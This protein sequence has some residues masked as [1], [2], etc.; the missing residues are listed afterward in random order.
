MYPQLDHEMPLID[1]EPSTKAK[2]KAKEEGKSRRN[3]PCKN[4]N[5]MKL[6]KKEVRNECTEKVIKFL[7]EPNTG[8]PTPT[9]IKSPTNTANSANTNTIQSLRE[10]GG[11]I[12]NV[13]QRFGLENSPWQL[14]ARNDLV[15]IWVPLVHRISVRDKKTIVMS[16]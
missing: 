10:Q 3:F 13:I 11:I 9:T 1:Q 14:I 15:F 2:A 5:K 4:P 7:T 6:Y 8:P 16:N 12:Q